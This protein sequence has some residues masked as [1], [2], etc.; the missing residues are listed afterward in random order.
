[1][2]EDRSPFPLFFGHDP[3]LVQI[4]LQHSQ[5]QS[6]GICTRVIY[7]TQSHL[8]VEHQTE[9]QLVPFIKSLV[10]FGLGWMRTLDLPN[11]KG[12][13]YHYTIESVKPWQLIYIN[14][15]DLVWRMQLMIIKG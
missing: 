14:D 15:S 3:I 2:V 5:A 12:T 10:R 8:Y 1:M 7:Q 9:K 11:S 6:Y 13:L 4:N